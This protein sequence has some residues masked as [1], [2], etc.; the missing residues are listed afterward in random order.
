MDNFEFRGDTAVLAGWLQRAHRL[1]DEDRDCA[2]YGWLLAWEAHLALMVENDSAKAIANAVKAAEMG[3]SL[4]IG[5]LEVLA[6]AAEGLALVTEGEVGLGMK[7]LDESCAAVMAGEVTDASARATTVCYLMDA[8]D[9]VRDYDRAEQWCE[10]AKEIAR[11]I[12]LDSLMGVCR[13]HFAVV[14]MWHGRWK[15]AEEQLLLA[16]A[17]VR[18]IRPAM[19]VEGLVRL[20]ELRWRQGRW[21]EAEELFERTRHADLSQLGRAELALSLG[22]LEEAGDLVAKY[23]RRIPPHDRIERAFGLDIGV[24]T[25]VANSDL[26]L[27]RQYGGELNSIAKT[28]GTEPMVAAARLASG[29]ISAATGSHAEARAALED[30]T[31]SYE[32]HGAP[33]E[34]AR[35]RLELAKS[36]A[37]LGRREQA[38]KECSLALELLKE[39]GAV[40]E[41]ERAVGHLSEIDPSARLP[42]LPRDEHDLSRRE[43][44]VLQLLAK[45]MSNQEIAASYVLSIRTVER[46]ISSIYDKIGAEG[47]S[48][49]AAASAYAVK[50]GLI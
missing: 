23:L 21:E 32:R 33:F 7:R 24:R 17:E 11:Q 10:R 25:A 26:M 38:V 9:R 27:A 16:D 40:K 1:L 18:E 46:H 48:A 49:R 30:A 39:I 35:A 50:R 31:D 47:R 45:G 2:D 6:L 12:H 20:G 13:P 42:V 19:V 3:R 22:R 43:L 5:D 28:V 14:L 41:A 4:Q 8:C 29:I 44:E 37:A 34:A 15:E 36:L